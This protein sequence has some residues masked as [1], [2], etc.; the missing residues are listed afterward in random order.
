[1]TY[2]TGRKIR[3]GDRVNLYGC[4]RGWVVNFPGMSGAVSVRLDHQ[5]PSDY[6]IADSQDL[7]F[8]P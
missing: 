3:I 4:Q 7:F 5:R 1:M 2:G 8:A 6:V